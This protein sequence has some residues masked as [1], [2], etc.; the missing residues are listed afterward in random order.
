MTTRDLALSIKRL[1]VFE[2][3]VVLAAVRYQL[4]R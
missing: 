1:L 4:L 2:P 3:N